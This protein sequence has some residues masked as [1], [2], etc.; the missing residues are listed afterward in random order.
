MRIAHLG[1]SRLGDRILQVLQSTDDDV[2]S[3]NDLEELRSLLDAGP[4]DWMVSAGFRYRVPAD[5]LERSKD[6]CNVHTSLLPWG[7]G[8]QPNIWAINDKEPA[9]VT[10]HRM[11]PQLD[12]GPIFA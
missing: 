6:S 12:A 8:S 9:G 10:I 5:C 11:T 4:A 2:E 7:R 1:G 3:A